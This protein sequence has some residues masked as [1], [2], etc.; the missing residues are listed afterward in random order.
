[1][2][3]AA[4]LIVFAGMAVLY[5]ASRNTADAPH[6]VARVQGH[7]G[8]IFPGQEGAV[9]VLSDGREIVLD[10]LQHKTVAGDG[11]MAIA[12]KKG[13]LSYANSNR[14]IPVT[15]NK[16]ITAKGREYR[17]VLEDGTRVWLN[18]GSSIRYP[19]RF[20]GSTREVMVTGETYF[21]V[22][23]DKTKPFYVKVRWGGQAEAMRI[24]VLG[25]HF[26]V[27]AYDDEQHITTTLFEGRVALES[28][29]ARTSLQPGEQAL[30]KSNFEIHRNF[31]PEEVLAWKNGYFHF[32]D[33]DI[34]T[35]MKGLKRWYDF[36]VEYDGPLPK[37]H[38][39]GKIPRDVEVSQVLEVLRRSS[40][41]FSV[42]GKKIIVR[43]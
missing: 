12:I 18:A 17:L 25:T 13:E 15:Y 42:E 19:V 9:L 20:T 21:E 22:A 29:A 41:N 23:P 27:N 35:V 24:A 43:Q 7:P 4:A 31:N 37:D 26:N 11:S 32:H 8:D 36:E 14:N 30:Y 28:E 38:F 33:A 34:E 2:R 40:V 16:L 10:S 1:M 39:G 3:Y 6:P 5:F